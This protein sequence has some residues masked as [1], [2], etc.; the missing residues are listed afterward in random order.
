MQGSKVALSVLDRSVLLSV[1]HAHAMS[2]QSGVMDCADVVASI[3]AQQKGCLAAAKYR[4]VPAIAERAAD[5]A[6]AALQNAE[7]SQQTL[8]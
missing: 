8:G 3:L 7:A 6:L 4:H 5:G 1:Q 2:C